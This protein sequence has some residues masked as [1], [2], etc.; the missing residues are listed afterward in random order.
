MPLSGEQGL[1]L[2]EILRALASAIADA[3]R[4]NPPAYHADPQAVR[5]LEQM[6]EQEVLPTERGWSP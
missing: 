4:D 6:E 3:R 1:G 2:T 5:E